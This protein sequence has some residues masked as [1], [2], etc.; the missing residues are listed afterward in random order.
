MVN[1]WKEKEGRREDWLPPST[2]SSV[3]GVTG[4]AE[5]LPLAVS[6]CPVAAADSSRLLTWVRLQLG[7]PPLFSPYL[8]RAS[9]ESGVN[10]ADLG[11]S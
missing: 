3:L 10:E 9:R 4:A 5:T 1:V 7:A 8:V 2:C 11:E 6:A